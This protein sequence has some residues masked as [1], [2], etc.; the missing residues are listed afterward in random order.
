MNILNSDINRIILLRLFSIIMAVLLDVIIGDPH[1]MPHIVKAFGKNI[2][3]IYKGLLRMF[4]VKSGRDEDANIKLMIGQTIVI[5]MIVGN[6]LI[7]GII[8]FVLDKYVPIAG[9][10][11][12]IIIIYQCI[13]ARQ[14]QKE[15]MVV[16]RELSNGINRGRTALSNIV[17]RDTDN[18]DYDAILRAD[19]ETVAENTSDGVIAPLFYIFIFGALGGVVYKV[20]NTMDSMLGYHSEEF[21]Y[22]GRAAAK[23]DDFFNFVPSRI[24]AGFMIISAYLCHMNGKGAVAIYKRDRK[25]S[26]SPNSAQ[27]ESVVAGALN[28]RLLGPARYGGVLHEKPYIGD[29]IKNIDAADVKASIKLMYSTE[30]ITLLACTLIYAAIIM[31]NYSF[32]FK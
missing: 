32:F 19:V 28:L 18:L 20:V 6:L 1:S 14:L 30:I 21:E 29:D 22:I 17:G 2:D 15:A 11:A 24:A 9:I 13:S 16:V 31:V 4:P 23:T 27:T 25:K 3:R 5:R 26:S 8:L 7:F 12:R 10:V